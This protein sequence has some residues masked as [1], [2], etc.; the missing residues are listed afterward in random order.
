[1]EHSCCTGPLYKP[2]VNLTVC[3]SGLLLSQLWPGSPVGQSGC[4]TLSIQKGGFPKSGWQA[5]I[6]LVIQQFLKTLYMSSTVL[7]AGNMAVNKTDKS[8]HHGDDIY[9]WQVVNKCQR[10]V[11]AR[12]GEWGR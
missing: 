10:V 5:F 3:L 2:V 1:M 11:H 4:Q 8:P 9:L 7:S 12:G 6:Y